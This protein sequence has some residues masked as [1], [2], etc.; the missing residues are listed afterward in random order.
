MEMA[1]H[2]RRPTTDRLACDRRGA[3]L[4]GSVARRR[5]GRG[6]TPGC[7]PSTPTHQLDFQRL[8]ARPTSGT[9]VQPP[10]EGD[11]G[12][13]SPYLT[14]RVCMNEGTAPGVRHAD[15]RHGRER[16]RV[17]WPVEDPERLDERRCGRPGSSRSPS[18]RGNFPT[19][20]PDD[21]ALNR[22]A[23]AGAA[24]RFGRMTER[25]LALQRRRWSG[26]TG[27][28][29]GP[30]CRFKLGCCEGEPQT[31]CDAPEASEAAARNAPSDRVGF[32]VLARASLVL[33]VGLVSVAAIPAARRRG[34][35]SPCRACRGRRG[36]ARAS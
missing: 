26:G 18:T 33:L 3:R 11:A 35:C 1:P 27:R 17:P 31:A 7:S 28:G 23:S 8:S 10:A 25:W 32:G 4:A 34:P 9:R 6:R 22:G 16:P 24:L 21:P 5:G 13:G 14:D 19:G 20:A 29:N 30:R 2:R 36:R 15:R 12:A